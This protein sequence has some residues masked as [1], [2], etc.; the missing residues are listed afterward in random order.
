M[1]FRYKANNFF[2]KMERIKKQMRE[3]FQKK[4][5]VKIITE[6]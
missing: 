3:N 6:N 2:K 1:K 4:M 5:W